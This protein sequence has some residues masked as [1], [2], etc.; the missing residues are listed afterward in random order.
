MRTFHFETIFSILEGYH[1][2]N[3]H[4][5][6]QY[7]MASA[8]S[9]L[10]M[11]GPSLPM[12]FWVFSISAMSFEHQCVFSSEEN[13]ESYAA[14]PSPFDSKPASLLL[15]NENSRRGNISS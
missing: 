4:L 2:F 13:G 10:W 11:C 12:I 9:L 15:D 5:N 3:A 8:S 14:I 1:L 6:R 7:V